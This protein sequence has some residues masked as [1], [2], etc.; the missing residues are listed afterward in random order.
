MLIWRYSFKLIVLVAMS[1]LIMLVYGQ[2]FHSAQVFRELAVEN[3]TEALQMLV[4]LKTND[5]IEQVRHQQKGFAL[6][7]QSQPQFMQA[8]DR[9]DKT[10]LQAWMLQY[11]AEQLEVDPGLNLK[12]L[13]VR[14]PGG[15]ILSRAS[16]KDLPGFNGCPVPHLLPGLATDGKF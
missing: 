4:A 14:G 3:Q 8:L 13:I 2:G 12:T 10:R 1:G 6:A 11:F 16:D 9:L 7:L 5:L 15:A